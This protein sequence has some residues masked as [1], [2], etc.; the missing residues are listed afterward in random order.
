MFPIKKENLLFILSVLILC[1]VTT[2]CATNEK[3]YSKGSLALSFRNKTASVAE[4]KALDLVHPIIVTPSLM[5]AHLLRLAYTH[6]ALLSKGKRIFTR[7]EALT[8]SK[9]LAKALK[10]ASPN[11]IVYFELDSKNGDITVELFASENKLHWLFTTIHGIRYA[12]NMLRGWGSTWR[13]IP[14][15]G[16]SHFTSEKILGTKTWDNW[17]VSNL[18]LPET[19][20]RK[21]KKK[22]RSKKRTTKTNQAP[23]VDINPELEEKLK[24]IKQLK[25]KGLIDEEEYKRKRK[26]LLDKHL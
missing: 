5:E 3:T 17:I 16:Q 1:L 11:K 9:V 20:K 7:E 10:K 14:Q 26:D 25:D 15:K 13:M 2:S 18:T 6:N 23:P 21:S 12:K 24:F 8:L 4:L 19:K 22:K